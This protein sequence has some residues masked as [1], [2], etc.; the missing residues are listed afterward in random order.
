MIIYK[1][2][3]IILF[4]FRI[5]ASECPDDFVSIN[6]GCYFKKHLDVLQDF[7]DINESIEKIEPQDIGTQAWRGGKLIYLYLGD[8]SLTAIPDSIGLLSDLGYLDLRKN[9]LKNIYLI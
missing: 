8:H 5:L 4:S 6:D 7:I 1:S 9:L 3:F 2:I